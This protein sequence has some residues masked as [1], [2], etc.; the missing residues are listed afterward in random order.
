MHETYVTQSIALS[1]SGFSYLV[2]AKPYYALSMSPQDRCWLFFDERTSAQDLGGIGATFEQGN[3]FG[4]SSSYRYGC[5][6]DLAARSGL[7]YIPVMWHDSKAKAS[8]R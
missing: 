6:G 1:N 4:H 3:E 7:C 2:S 8:C 5:F